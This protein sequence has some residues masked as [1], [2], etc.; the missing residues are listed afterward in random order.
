MWINSF[1]RTLSLVYLPHLDYVMQR[2]GGPFDRAQGRLMGRAW[3]RRWRP[4]IEVIGELA[5]YY[6][7][8]QGVGV[9][10]LSEY[11]IGK[12]SRPVHLNRVLREHGLIAIREEMGGELLDAGASA[13]FAVAD[14]QVAHV[15]VNDK[16]RLEE[17]RKLLIA[18]NTGRGVGRFGEKEKIDA[19]LN[20]AAQR[21]A[22]GGRPGADAWFHL[23]PI[24]WTRPG[25]RIL[26][27]LWISIT[28]PDTTRPMDCFWIRQLKM[29]KVKIAT[30]LL[31][32]KLGQRTLMEVIPPHGEMVRV[33]TGERKRGRC[34]SRNEGIY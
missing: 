33:R 23:L 26:P 12:V 30:T 5:D 27:E 16:A 15:Y 1:I 31:K 21:R 7:A 22:G 8:A 17:V 29:P 28:S 34:W 3:R 24:G 14:H 4:W 11:G 6:R 18:Q 32:K 25:C 2:E 20:H 13:A 19:H 9:V 10:V